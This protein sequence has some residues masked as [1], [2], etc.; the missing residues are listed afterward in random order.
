M[1]PGKG[2][3]LM[4]QGHVA[5]YKAVS[6]LVLLCSLL[7]V[8]CQHPE[9]TERIGLYFKKKT[10]TPALVPTFEKSR[11]A[12]PVPILSE[13]PGW[14]DMYWKT[15]QI[16]FT[17]IKSPLPG[18]PFVS[19]Y[20]G[21]AFSQSIFQWDFCF[22][23]MFAK[24]IYHEFPSIGSLDNFYCRQRESGYICREIQEEDGAE[25]HFEG[26]ENTINPPL[27]AW[28]EWEWY[29]FSGDSSRFAQVL[30]ALEKYYAWIEQ[31]R[32]D[33]SGDRGLFWQTALGSG[34]DNS[35]RSGSAWVDMSAQM[36]L[37]YRCLS[38]MCK[39][40]GETTKAAEYAGKAKALSSRINRWMWDEKDGFYYDINADGTPVRA[41]T[42]AGFWPLV[43]EVASKQ[44]AARLVQH[45]ED[46]KEF[47]RPMPFASLAASD[48]LYQPN[49]GY[50]RGGVWSP[51]NYMIIRGLSDYGYEETAS[52]AAER[53]LAGM[54]DVF[55]K[56][57]TVWEFY[58][59]DSLAPG[60]LLHVRN[61]ANVGE[62][63]AKKDLVGWT[64]LGPVALLIEGVI[65]IR[66]EGAERRIVWRIRRTDRNGIRGIRMADATVS[67]VCEKRRSVDSTAHVTVESDRAF[68][69]V[70]VLPKE[71]KTVTVAAGKTELSMP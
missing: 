43:A 24:Y 19:N 44:Q 48:T 66:C 69:L 38:S 39:V 10:Y 61:T 1:R 12:I 63:M 42:I 33:T 41:K 45:L 49:G 53:Y 37:A 62:K 9:H 3:T 15:W 20:W 55:K 68:E 34:M 5:D 29:T 40:Q 31:N 65:G 4:R 8:Q 56:T 46:R 57:G 27:F 35:P 11:P 58:A 18:S 54:Y 51:T 64:G 71:T 17:N 52:K 7:L 36:V 23:Q 28:A 2:N 50:W 22:I 21:A 25:F 26:I 47:N 70:L 60:K 13:S 59:P 30:P 67:L 14:I 16:G 6:L 32:S